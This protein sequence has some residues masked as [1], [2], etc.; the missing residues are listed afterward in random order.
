MIAEELLNKES[1][2]SLLLYTDQA[3]FLFD[4]CLDYKHLEPL[5]DFLLEGRCLSP[6]S[7]ELSIYAQ[8]SK[9]VLDFEIYNLELAYRRGDHNAVDL[10]LECYRIAAREG[11]YEA[12]NNIGVFLAMTDRCNEALPYWK[13]AAE[14]GSSCGWINLLGYF[15]SHENYKDM[16][17]CINKLAELNDPI[18]YWNMAVA[19]HFGNLGLTPDIDKAMTI[20]NKMRSLMPSEEDNEIGN[21]NI[22]LQSKT[23]ANYNLAKIR[24]LTEKHT[25]K[26]LEDILE[27]FTSTPYVMLDRPRENKFISEIRGLIQM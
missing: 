12:Y 1:F 8:A 6:F 13:K 9:C 7:E 2:Y 19:H 5:N 4:R 18:G 14:S 16:I 21:A 23:M 15:G 27:M 22:L 26:N 3:S 11:V 24:F 25:K 17:L 20:Y 10:M